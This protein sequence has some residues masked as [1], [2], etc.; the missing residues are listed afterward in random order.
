MKIAIIQGDL[1]KIGGSENL[2]IWYS[3][4]LVKRGYA[5]TIFTGAYEPKNWSTEYTS[6]LNI[7]I[8]KHFGFK[9]NPFTYQVNGVHALRLTAG[10]D[11]VIV[12][13]WLN[14]SL[15]IAFRG[16]RKTQKWV[17]F[18]EE[19]PRFIYYKE[20]DEELVR[21]NLNHLYLE[22]HKGI[23]IILNHAIRKFLIFFK[24][25]DKIFVRYTFDKI[26]V[27]SKFT[28]RNI[29]KIYNL[30]SKVALLGIGTHYT[31]ENYVDMKNRLNCDVL[32][33]FSGRLDYSKNLTRIINAV[34]LIDTNINYKLVIAG[35]GIL[36]A[37]LDK[38]VKRLN[39]TDKV[40]LTGRIP[41]DLL[42][43]Y[44]NSADLIIYLPINEPFGLVPIEA[45]A[46]GKPSIVSSTGGPSETIINNVTGFYA[47]PLDTND[48]K[49]KIEYLLA[50]KEFLSDKSE[51]CKGEYEQKFTLEKGVDRLLN[52]LKKEIV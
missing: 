6:K 37:Y 36:K 22:P 21:Y 39:L 7:V 48:I 49:S 18:C 46:C 3:A 17:W 33:F 44:M 11:L 28:G 5:I 35:D 38:K 25:L 10:Y 16:Q 8:D 26:V 4:E 32:L 50:H 2:I 43:S 45:M 27:N 34:S 52:A 40:L 30:P 41:T 1:S 24:I 15:P 29:K 47:N 13:S 20:I 42:V 23:N 12:H 19:P 31:T 51:I 14:S 9:R